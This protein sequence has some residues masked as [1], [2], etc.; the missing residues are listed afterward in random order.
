M[1][2]LHAESEKVIQDKLK[3]YLNNS[4]K[5]IFSIDK[6][7]E[8]SKYREKIEVMVFDINKLFNESYIHIEEQESLYRFNQNLLYDFSSKNILNGDKITKLNNQEITLLEYLIKH[9]GTTISYE[10]LMY[11]ISDNSYNSSSIE[12][13]R[14]VI[15]RLRAKTDKSIIDTI[16]KV[17]YALL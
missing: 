6:S 2:L 14:T 1:S 15:K 11:V 13:L 3:L 10:T 7:S 12:T 8:I 17:G 16:S 9:R 5:E 4:V